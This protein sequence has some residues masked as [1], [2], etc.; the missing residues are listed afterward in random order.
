VESIGHYTVVRRLGEGGMAEVFLARDPAAGSGRL[1][2][3]KRVR[4]ELCG[5][6]RFASMFRAEARVAMA[7]N[8]PNIAHVYEF[9]AQ[10]RQPFLAL[11]FVHGADLVDLIRHR[12]LRLEAKLVAL[13]GA[14]VA[15]ALHHVHTRCDPAGRPLEAIHRDIKPS[16][17]RVSHEG[18]VKVLDFGVVKASTNS[19]ATRQGVLKGTYSHMSPEQVKGLPLDG[20]SDLFSLGVV[21]HEL[22]SAKQLFLAGTE[23]ETLRAIVKGPIPTPSQVSGRDVP[24]Q[25]EQIV[26]RLL[27]RDPERRWPDAQ[28]LEQA[29][30]VYLRAFSARE[31]DLALYV[32]RLKGDARTHLDRLLAPEPGA[33]AVSEE[34]SSAAT[35]APTRPYVSPLSEP[36]DDMD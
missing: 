25:L 35:A 12:Q 17:I 4:P 27:A 15:A 31:D 21:L 34:P 36:D 18:E 29:L 6:E 14:R 10:G 16:N 7:L 26:M 2:V 5:V 23:M 20:R 30:G 13:V 19:Q 33:A 32:S 9:G 1:L 8:H 24:H 11:E 22:L 28:A 3:I